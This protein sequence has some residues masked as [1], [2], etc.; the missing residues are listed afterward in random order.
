FLALAVAAIIFLFGPTL[1]LANSYIQGMGE[2]GTS[3]LTMGTMTTETA[4][5]WWMQ[6][7]TVFFFAWFLGY[8]P[9]MALFVARISRG[10]SIRQMILAVGVMAPIA[11]TIWFTLVGGSGIYYQLNGVIDLREALAN[12]H[13][14]VATITIAQAMPMG[15]F[16][17][18]LMLILT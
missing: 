13:F 14:D 1:F 7:W 12:F 6:W 15:D 8:G 9:L 18:M 4:P 11:T 16:M 3:F 5:A 2:Y 10:R 17:A